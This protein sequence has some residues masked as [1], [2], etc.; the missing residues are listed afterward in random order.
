[1]EDPYGSVVP[2]RVEPRPSLSEWR[3]KEKILTPSQR[4]SKSCA[5]NWSGPKGLPSGNLTWDMI[6][7]SYHHQL[8]NNPL[9]MTNIAIEN[10]HF[11]WENPLF[12]WS[13]SIATLNYQR[14]IKAKNDVIQD[15]DLRIQDLTELC[16]KLTDRCDRAMRA[17]FLEISSSSGSSDDDS[18]DG[19]AASSNEH[20]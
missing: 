17:G 9:V 19:E 12:L 20:A 8:T 14:F 10:H 2:G 11:E 1:M 15:R 18:N 7:S 13:F 16:N 6:Q 5:N 3:I 4:S